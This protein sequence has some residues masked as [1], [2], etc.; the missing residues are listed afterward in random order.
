PT[1]VFAGAWAALATV[2]GAA[3]LLGRWL[4]RRVRLSLVRYLAAAVCLVLAV[5]TLID[6]FRGV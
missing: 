2:S 3:V 1:A 5:T 4:L 6:I